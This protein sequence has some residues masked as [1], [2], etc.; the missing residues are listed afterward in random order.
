MRELH[1][2]IWTTVPNEAGNL[3]LFS[4]RFSTGMCTPF[5]ENDPWH[6]NTRCILQYVVGPE[7]TSYIYNVLRQDGSLLE[8]VPKWLKLPRR[9][10][11]AALSNCGT[12]LSFAP[13]YAQGD[14]EIVLTAVASDPFALTY[15]SP[16]LKRDPEVR[17]TTSTA[18][19]C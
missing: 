13:P 5:A 19:E 7:H 12:A 6:L 8:Y 9:V 1:A 18:A 11:F 2:F 3:A 14:K 17:V 10:L 15:A 4:Y 16:S